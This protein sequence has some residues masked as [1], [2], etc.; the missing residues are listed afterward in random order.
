[1]VQR[2]DLINY[3]ENLIPTRSEENGLVTSNAE[4]SAAIIAIFT[5]LADSSCLGKEE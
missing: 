1:M 3:L 4:N 5:G 2:V